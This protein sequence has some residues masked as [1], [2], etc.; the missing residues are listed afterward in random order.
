MRKK[1]R[2]SRKRM[3]RNTSRK[4]T[5]NKS[6]LYRYSN[7]LTICSICDSSSTKSGMRVAAR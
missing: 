1:G 5:E 3:M 7:G 4:R 2:R 6:M